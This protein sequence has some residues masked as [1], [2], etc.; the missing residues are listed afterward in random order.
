MGYADGGEGWLNVGS[1]RTSIVCWSSAVSTMVVMNLKWYN[2]TSKKRTLLGLRLFGCLKVTRHKVGKRWNLKHPV[3][4][5]SGDKSPKITVK[6]EIS[7]RKGHHNR[8]L[9]SRSIFSPTKR[10]ASLCV[11]RNQDRANEARFL[12][13]RHVDKYPRFFGSDARKEKFS[14]AVPSLGLNSNAHNLDRAHA[15]C[16]T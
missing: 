15:Q 6:I 9:K 16:L 5:C 14:W 3:R 11:I 13:K 4:Y 8:T 1:R 10:M 2:Q 7:R 12:C